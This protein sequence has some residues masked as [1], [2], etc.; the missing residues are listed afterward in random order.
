MAI[1]AQ[2]QMDLGGRS[3]EVVAAYQTQG[4]KHQQI[5][6]SLG[7]KLAG[8]EAN[9]WHINANLGLTPHAGLK[10]SYLTADYKATTGDRK[11]TS[12][13]AW[14]NLAQNITFMPEYTSWS[15]DEITTGMPETQIIALFVVGF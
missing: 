4:K 11:A 6:D 8:I 1:D 10:L 13:G 2:L 7:N 15:G 3:L 9:G 5:T 12:V 14:I